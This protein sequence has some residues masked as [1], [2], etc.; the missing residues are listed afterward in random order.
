LHTRVSGEHSSALKM[1]VRN[2]ETLCS[3]VGD[4]RDSDEA[5]TLIF[6]VK[7]KMETEC[8]SEI[9]VSIY[10]FTWCHNPEDNNLNTI[11]YFILTEPR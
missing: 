10:L 9:L 11:F 8:S 7:M 3:L 4:C 6:K 5:V 1:W 2:K